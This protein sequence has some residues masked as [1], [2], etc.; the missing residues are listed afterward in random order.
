MNIQK[1]FYFKCVESICLMATKMKLQLRSKFYLSISRIINFSFKVIDT[2]CLMEKE[3]EE[4]VSPFE[5][6]NVVKV[7]KALCIVSNC[8]H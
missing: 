2:I 4:L 8:I 7:L 5:S 3:T 1:Y 6:H